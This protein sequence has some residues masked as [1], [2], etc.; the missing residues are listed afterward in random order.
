MTLVT[1]LVRSDLQ[2]ATRTVFPHDIY[3]DSR[4]EQLTAAFTHRPR[5]TPLSQQTCRLILHLT[6]VHGMRQVYRQLFHTNYM[7]YCCLNRYVGS[8]CTSLWCRYIDSRA[9]NGLT[10]L[11]L[12]AYSGSL[13]CVRL[14]L[15]NGAS[16]MVRTVDLDVV[17]EVAAPAGSTPL[18]IASM[19]GSVAILQA[20]LQV[21]CYLHVMEHLIHV[22]G[23]CMLL[24]AAWQSCMSLCHA[25]AEIGL[26]SWAC[27]RSM[28]SEQQKCL[29]LPCKTMC[30][31]QAN[32]MCT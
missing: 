29:L 8:Y 13:E 10:A 4:A 2:L 28:L 6:S 17:S 14:L 20:M 31:Q 3:I 18:H 15:D 22:C 21:T 12:A 5:A 26:L 1:P 16:M 7:Q 24:S 27:L 25:T 30:M 19:K 32:A 11:H 9:E 23:S